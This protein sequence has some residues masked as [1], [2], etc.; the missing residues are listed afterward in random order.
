MVWVTEKFAKERA[1]RLQQIHL[2]VENCH[3]NHRREKI[4]RTLSLGLAE[5]KPMVSALLKSDIKFYLK[6]IYLTCNTTK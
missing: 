6:L 5:I 2:V 4:L 1:L 3:Q